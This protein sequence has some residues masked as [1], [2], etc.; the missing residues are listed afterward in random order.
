MLSLTTKQ[1]DELLTIYR[2]DPDPEVRFRAHILLLLDDGHTWDTIEAMLFCSSRTVDR[3]L[4]RFQAE[5][6]DGL[7][8]QEARPPLSPRARLGRRPR[9]L[10]DHQDAP[11]TSASSAAAGPAR[12]WPSCSASATASTVSRET[13]RRWLHR[14]D[15]VYRR[16]R[17]VLAPNEDR[18]AGQA[19]RPAGAA[20]RACPPTRR[21]SSRTRWTSTPTPR[22]AR[23]WMLKGRA[24]DGRDAGH[25]REAVPV[26]VDPLADRPGVRHR[27]RPRSR[28]ATRRCS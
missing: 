19:G 26:R 21:R 3:W 22:S 25:Q 20:G 18:A 11:A 1:R 2:K 23:M 8:G 5:G 27:G 12:R 9:H 15:L 13:V 24:G 4:K 10:G 14:G 28:A 7:T 6:V 17:P 16:P